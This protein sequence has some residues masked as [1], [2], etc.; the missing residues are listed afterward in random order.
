MLSLPS[1]SGENTG[2]ELTNLVHFLLC[3]KRILFSLGPDFA[4]LIL[5]HRGG[6]QD[7]SQ[8]ALVRERHIPDA[9]HDDS[10]ASTVAHDA[11]DLPVR[12]YEDEITDSI[13]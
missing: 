8:K 12:Y 13:W 11:R 4:F 9:D 2:H 10:I 7:T 3:T 6:C 1:T 5:G